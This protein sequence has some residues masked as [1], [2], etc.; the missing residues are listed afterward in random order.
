MSQLSKTTGKLWATMA[1]EVSEDV[2][3]SEFSSFV[4]LVLAQAKY[5]LFENKRY[6]D[7]RQELETDCKE[8][9]KYALRGIALS[10]DR[11][12]TVTSVK[13]PRIVSEILQ[14]TQ[15]VLSIAVKWELI[16]FEDSTRFG[17]Y[18]GEK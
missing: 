15:D 18:R 6:I 2:I 11:D 7:K 8:L 5:L 3:L 4:G 17:S 16:E 9:S 10:R 14:L 12:I 13:Y 1:G